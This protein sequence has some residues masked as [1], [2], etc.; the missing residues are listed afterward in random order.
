MLAIT[1]FH[2]GFDYLFSHAGHRERGDESARRRLRR[3]LVAGGSVRGHPGARLHL[4]R[5]R[6]RRRRRRGGGAGVQTR[7][8]SNHLVA[9]DRGG[10]E[11]RAGR[12]AHPRH[13][14][15]RE[16]AEQHGERWRAVPD[17]LERLESGHPGHRAVRRV[18]RLLQ[19]RPGD[20]GGRRPAHLLVQP[21][22]RAPG[23]RHAFAAC[24]RGFARRS[25]R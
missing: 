16:R 21:R 14:V 4:L 19:L 3:Q 15:R 13:P 8:P 25:T 9:A 12:R 11:L 2:H 23:E 6:V 17:Q 7:A 1:G 24:R 20:P 22:P 5:L 18:F 10:H